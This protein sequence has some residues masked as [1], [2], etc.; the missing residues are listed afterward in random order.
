MLAESKGL[1]KQGTKRSFKN[2]ESTPRA[3]QGM[4]NRVLIGMHGSD[5]RP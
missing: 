4:A 5:T 1:C 2:L 3:F